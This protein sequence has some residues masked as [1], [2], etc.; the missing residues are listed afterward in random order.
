[1]SRKSQLKRRAV[2]A[3]TSLIKVLKESRDALEATPDTQISSLEMTLAFWPCHTG[4]NNQVFHHQLCNLFSKGQRL[5]GLHP[6]WH[7]L[8]RLPEMI[9]IERGVLQCKHA[10]IIISGL[11][12]R[13]LHVDRFLFRYMARHVWATRNCEEWS[14]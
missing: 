4:L 13:L 3:I 8:S 5:Q 2:N 11:K 12:K 10:A 7:F 6:R 1:M 14:L 9:A